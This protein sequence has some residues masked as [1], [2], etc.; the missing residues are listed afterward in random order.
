MLIFVTRS[1]Y[2]YYNIQVSVLPVLHL[3][4]CCIVLLLWKVCSAGDGDGDDEDED[5]KGDKITLL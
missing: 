2:S 5:D 4:T 3:H 1:S